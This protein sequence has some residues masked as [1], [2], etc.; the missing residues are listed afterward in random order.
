MNLQSHSRFEVA[1]ANFSINTNHGQ[2]NEIS[3]RS[4][5]RSIHGGALR[6]PPLGGV[7]A[8]NVRNRPDS[9]KEGF[10]ILVA[11]HLGKRGSNK[12]THTRIFFK[13]CINKFYFFARLDTQLLRQSK[14]RQTVNDPEVHRLR[15]A[16]VIGSNHQ[17][18]HTKNLRRGQSMNI[19]ATAK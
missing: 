12:S 13:I 1:L 5:Q 11:T 4:L 9:T 17:R 14:W 19:I 3:R 6:K 18:G 2:L 8:V 15:L 10:Y 16:P 7:L